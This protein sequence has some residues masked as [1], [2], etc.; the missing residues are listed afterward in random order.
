[1]LHLLELHAGHRDGWRP[2]LFEAGFEI[3]G[4]Q[5]VLTDE[6]RSPYARYAAQVLQ[7]A[8]QQDGALALLAT[9]AVDGQDMD[10]NRGSVRDVLC[11]G[12]LKYKWTKCEWITLQ[13]NI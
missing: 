13:L 8:P 3:E 9:V 1:M 7:V 11:H 10:V 2:F 5:E 12:L 4:H 6:Q